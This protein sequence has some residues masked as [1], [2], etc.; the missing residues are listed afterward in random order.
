MKITIIPGWTV[1]DV[2]NYLVEIKVLSSA[3][4]FLS[5]CKSGEAYNGYYFIEE[6]MKDRH[7]QPA[8]VCAGGLSLAE[9]LRNL[10]QLKRGYPHQASA[11]T[12]G[13]GL[14]ERL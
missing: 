10:Y 3:D 5:L 6:V 4:E 8:E 13:G 14:S 7:G 2:A 11:H 9:Y 1:E 12:D